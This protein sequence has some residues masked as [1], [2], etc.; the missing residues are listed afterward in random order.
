MP[1]QCGHKDCFIP[2]FGGGYCT[3]HQHLRTD[4]KPTPL[5][6][7]PVNKVSK[8]RPLVAR[9]DRV[10]YD[11]VWAIRPHNCEECGASLGDH[12]DAIYFS[13]ILSKGAHPAMRHDNRNI[14]LLCPDHHRQWEFG[15]RKNMR[16]FETN[17]E[18][19]EELKSEYYGVE[20]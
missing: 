13:H 6:K 17:L 8:K 14:N 15:G 7:T 1:K 5:K 20:L 4:K 3:F 19:M 18:T 2:V 16:I 9:Q 10:L 11:S 12:P